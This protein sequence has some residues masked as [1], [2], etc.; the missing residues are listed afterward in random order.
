VIGHFG[1]Q[2]KKR[3]GIRL[4]KSPHPLEFIGPGQ[5]ESALHLRLADQVPALRITLAER[6]PSNPFDV[7]VGTHS[8]FVAAFQ[9]A[10][11]EHGPPIGGGHASAKAMY[12]HATPNLRLIRSLG[13]SISSHN[14]MIAFSP[15]LRTPGKSAG[16]GKDWQRIIPQGEIFGQL[17]CVS[18]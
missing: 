5:A 11:F 16:T 2:H 10:A 15:G 8:Q 18:F 12:A 14:K 6:L 1:D 9:A 7:L 4:T 13:H 3:V 17:K